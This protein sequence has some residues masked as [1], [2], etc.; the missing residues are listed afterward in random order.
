MVTE[1]ASQGFSAEGILDILADL[2]AGMVT[3]H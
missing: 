1:V 2:A 3:S